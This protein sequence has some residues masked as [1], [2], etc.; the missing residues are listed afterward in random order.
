M[1]NEVASGQVCPSCAAENPPFAA[2]CSQCGTALGRLRGTRATYPAPVSAPSSAVPAAPASSAAAAVPAGYQT[3]SSVAPYPRAGAPTPSNGATMQAQYYQQHSYGPG[4]AGPAPQGYYPAAPISV[5]VNPVINV[6][7]PM[8]APLEQPPHPTLIVHAPVAA[9]SIIVRALWFLF[10]GLWLGA[11]ATVVG[12]ALC[13]SVIGLPLGLLILNRLPA[14]MTLRPRSTSLRVTTSYGVTVVNYVAPAQ[15][16]MAAR[17]AYFLLIGWWFSALWLLM[18]WCL[19]GLSVVTFGISL[20][21]AFMM[22]DRVPQVLT[23]RRN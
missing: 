9:P 15:H 2:Y 4:Y 1:M 3:T 11:L 20:A 14:I 19:V 18:A 13:V 7:A 5:N 10:V 8:P 23:L 16:A 17:A 22:F 6:Q 21:P 12:W